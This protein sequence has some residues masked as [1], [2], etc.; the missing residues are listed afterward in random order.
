MQRVLITGMSGTGKSTV[1][2][3]LV[4]RGYKAVDADDPGWSELVDVAGEA[5]QDWVWREDRIAALLASEDADILFISGCATNQ[6][7]F[8]PQFDHIVLLSAP[9]PLMLERLATRTTNAYGKRPDELA[10]VVE[11]QQTIEPLLR[12]GA[13]LEV[14]A[15]VPVEQV[16]EAVLAHVRE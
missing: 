10:R 11:H 16:V 12:R 14:D 15:S 3:A 5:N 4:E 7:T 6:G 2:R 8:Y 13:T 1:I 9:L